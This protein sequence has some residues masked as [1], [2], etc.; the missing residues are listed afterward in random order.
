MKETNRD[1]QHEQRSA[2]RQG[3]SSQSTRRPGSGNQSATTHRGGTERSSDAAQE[4]KHNR[5]FTPL[6]RDDIY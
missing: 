4:H 3:S 6:D 5:R 1:K 2:E